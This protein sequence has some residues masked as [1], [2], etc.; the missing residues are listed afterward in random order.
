MCAHSQFFPLNYNSQVYFLLLLIIPSLSLRFCVHAIIQQF[1][2]HCGMLKCNSCF[3]LFCNTKR[4]TFYE[5]EY[6]L[7]K[8]KNK[9][10]KTSHDEQFFIVNIYV[11]FVSWSSS[12]MLRLLKMTFFY[13]SYVWSLRKMDIFL[14]SLG[15]S[16]RLN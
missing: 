16:C 8:I 14:R 4:A 5:W 6:F 2:L 10:D 7:R 1:I 15:E 3:F 9:K 13:R 11:L 12:S